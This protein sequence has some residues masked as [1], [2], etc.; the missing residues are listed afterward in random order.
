MLISYEGLQCKRSMKK[1]SSILLLFIYSVFTLNSHPSNSFWGGLDIGYGLSLSDKGDIYKYSTNNENKM[2]MSS[3]RAIF[4]YY[5]N[6]K[7]SIGLNLGLNSFSKPTVNTV[8]IMLDVRYHPISDNL[9]FFL[10]G[11]LGYSTLT[12]EEELKGKLVFDLSI[13]YKISQIGK[14]KISPSIGYNYFNY[15]LKQPNL[16][17]NRHSII[18]R[19]GLYF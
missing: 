19:I 3:V 7:L 16:S 13:G 4:G 18:F 11:D 1:I 6:Q 9:S 12:S 5:L 14:M 15:S 2:T 17:Q 10:Q 8:P